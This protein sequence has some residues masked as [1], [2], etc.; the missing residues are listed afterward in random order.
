M[1]MRRNLVLFF[2]CFIYLVLD[3]LRGIEVDEEVEFAHPVYQMMSFSKSFP[4]SF[5]LRALQMPS[6]ISISYF[7]LLC[8][9]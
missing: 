7:L 2:V 6:L 5:G 4:S 1:A 8:C 9:N 3:E